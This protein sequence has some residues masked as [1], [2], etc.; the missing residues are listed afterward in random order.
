MKE[1]T[2]LVICRGGAKVF[3]DKD[4]AFAYCKA[5][6]KKEYTVRLYK[7][8]NVNSKGFDIL[9]CIYFTNCEQ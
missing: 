1:N 9:I 4:F 2:Y 8:E 3:D 7:V 5:C 6:E